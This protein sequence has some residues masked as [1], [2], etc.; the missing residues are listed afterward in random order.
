MDEFSNKKSGKMQTTRLIWG[1]GGPGTLQKD[2]HGFSLK[3]ELVKI[4]FGHVFDVFLRFLSN[5]HKQIKLVEIV[6]M[7]YVY[8]K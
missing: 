7:K 6:K 3:F 4:F 2:A 8:A 1:F 5:K